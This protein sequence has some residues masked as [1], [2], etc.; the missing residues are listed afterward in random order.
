[1]QFARFVDFRNLRN[2]D[3][4]FQTKWLGKICRLSI[5]GRINTELGTKIRTSHK[6]AE[7][8]FRVCLPCAF[9]CVFLAE[10]LHV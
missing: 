10:W 9:G 8:C 4:I 7:M 6:S 5:F 1:M 3:D 2:L